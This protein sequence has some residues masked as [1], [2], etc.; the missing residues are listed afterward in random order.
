MEQVQTLV[1]LLAARPLEP[2]GGDVESLDT[3][4]VSQEGRWG[5]DVEAGIRLTWRQAEDENGLL[6]PVSRLLEQT[7]ENLDSAALPPPGCR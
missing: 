6:M 4:W 2:F 7:G 1:E 3:V 5:S